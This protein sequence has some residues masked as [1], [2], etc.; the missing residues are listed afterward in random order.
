MFSS[1]KCS[2]HLAAVGAV[3]DGHAVD[4]RNHIRIASEVQLEPRRAGRHVVRVGARAAAPDRVPIAV[5]GAAGL[6]AP[7]DTRLT[8][9]PTDAAIAV[10]RPGLTRALW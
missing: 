1:T 9:S 10:R 6:A 2:R 4:H 5:Y 3:I 8:R 7:A